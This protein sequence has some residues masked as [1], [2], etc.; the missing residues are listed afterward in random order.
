MLS[1]FGFALMTVFVKLATDIGPVQKTFFRNIIAALVALVVMLA[2]G[3]KMRWPKDSTALLLARCTFGTLGILLNFYSVD[4]LFL[5]DA[6]VLQKISPFVIVI[7]SAIFFKERIGKHQIAALIIGFIGI[8]L[9]VKPSGQGLVSLG[10][11]AAI[12]GAISAGAAYTCIRQLAKEG[13]KGSSIV[14]FFSLFSVVV[15]LPYVVLNY[16]YMSPL[17]WLYVAGIGAFATIGQFGITYGYTYAPAKSVSVF[18]YMQVLFAA[19]FGLVLFAEVP[20]MYSIAGY[21]VISGVGIYMVLRDAR[22]ERKK[23]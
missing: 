6:N 5:G 9:V 16:E 22:D 3:D 19:L 2:S 20:D 1:A 17:T 7:L 4:H 15:L 11:L 18:E 23:A 13:V 8:I 12:A 14:F 10:A 21:F